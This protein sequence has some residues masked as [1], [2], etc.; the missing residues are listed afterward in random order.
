LGDS[1]QNR[2]GHNRRAPGHVEGTVLAPAT[3]PSK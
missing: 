1:Y 3:L 2:E